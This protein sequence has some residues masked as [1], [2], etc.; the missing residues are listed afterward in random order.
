MMQVNEYTDRSVFL[1]PFLCVFV[2]AAF[3][4]LELFTPESR[5]T[6][7]GWNLVQEVLH[8]SQIQ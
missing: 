1:H 2:S 3:S 4:W 6:E 7:G 5:I 8:E